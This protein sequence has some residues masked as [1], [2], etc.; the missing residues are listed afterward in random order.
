LGLALCALWL[1]LPLAA[2]AQT[3]TGATL[4]GRVEDGQKSPLPGVTVSVTDKSTGFSRVTVTAADG[5]FR[6]PSLPVGVYSVTAELAGFATVTVEA[7]QLT[8]ATERKLEVTMNPATLEEHITVVDEAPLVQ[9]SPSIGTTVDRKELENLPLNGRQFANLA[10]LAP[11]TTLAVNSDPTKPGQQVVAMNGGAGRNVSYVIDGGDNAD[12]TIGGALQNFNLESVQEFKIQ[13]QQY[14]AEFGRSSGG[15]LS[16]VTKTGTNTFEGSTYGFFRDRRL[17][18]RTESQARAGV[19]KQ[20]FDRKQY[21]ASFGGPIVKDKAHFFATWE[22]TQRK[23][24]YT[25]NTLGSL[26]ELDGRSTPVPFLDELGTAKASY[27]ISARQYLQV[28]YGYQKNNDKYGASPLA[29]P[30]ALGTITNDYKSLLAG[31]TIQ[32]GAEALNEALFQYTHFKNTIAADSTAP[33]LF[34]PSGAKSGQNPNTPQSTEQAKYQYKDDFSG[35]HVLGGR[36]HDWKV[37]FN[38]VNEPT[39]KAIFTTGLNG[40]YTLG[41]QPGQPVT[42]IVI[43]GGFAGESTPIKQ[44]S[45]YVQDDWHA[46]DRLTINAGL[47]YDYWDGFDIDQRSNAIW[48]TLATQTQYHESY[49]RD[50]A[51]G[52]QLQNDKNDFGPRL[53]FTWDTRGDGRH[54]LRGGWGLYYDFPYTNATLLFPAF[55]VQSNYGIAYIANDP[56]GFRNPDGT[57][58]RPGQPL[59]PNQLG[60]NGTF[61]PNDVASPTLKTPRSTQ[62][63]LGYSWQVNSWLG[64]NFEAVDVQYRDIP[65]AFHANPFVDTNGNHKVDPDESRRFPQF[66]SFNLWYGKGKASYDGVNLGAHVRLSRF[67]LQGFYTLSRA[68][69]NVL[70]GADDFRLANFNYQ[71][72]LA[73]PLRAGVP[74][75]PLNPLCSAC[76]GPLNTDARHR[77]TLAGTLRTVHGIDVSGIFRYHSATPYTSYAGA[78]LNGDGFD[79][80][81][82]PG[83]K[84]VNAAR[85]A[86]FSQL[87]LRVSKAFT[88]ADHLSVELIAE[89]FNLL[90]AKNPTGFTGDQQ[91]AN[92]GK[93]T[94]FAGDPLQGEQRLG[95]LGLRIR[96]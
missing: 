22:K 42:G 58:F 47:R 92:F 49:L 50:F 79:L 39:L 40:Q 46:G 68:T 14:K 82:P 29:A 53:G 9:T 73:N 72:D 37:G 65:F 85:G 27:D 8:V 38:Y 86:S 28:R 6:L 5:G 93:P 7:V 61:P 88:F 89:V 30:S 34:Y 91:S 64:L 80:D 2:A 11:G 90:N 16:V 75:D 10:T 24:S 78:D 3:A 69:G 26:P 63:S 41:N 59:P 60:G 33:T 56:D 44:Y 55:A 83:I 84:H 32:L 66:G 19:D 81:L 62:S 1:C 35:S 67:E 23:T 76:I 18:T 54:L 52:K 36:R 21:G 25:V 94:S 13:T 96:F 70:A 77:V 51:G 4:A 12:D 48:Q 74:A 15:V 87:D 95:Q 45:G 20:P 17:N 57:L 31:H 71:P 43:F